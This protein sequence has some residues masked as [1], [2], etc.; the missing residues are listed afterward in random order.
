MGALPVPKLSVEDYLA[1]DRA[2]EA[3]SEYHDGEVFPIAAVTWKHGRLSV[4]LGRRIDER[5][6]IPPT[7]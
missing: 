1:L 6:E 5:L 7:G 2:A 3:K 4:R